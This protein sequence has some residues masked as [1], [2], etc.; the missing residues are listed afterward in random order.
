MHNSSATQVSASTVDTTTTGL[1][2]GVEGAPLDDD[3]SS[4]YLHKYIIYGSLGALLG[5]F[6]VVFTIGL[7]VR[8]VKKKREASRK[9]SETRD[10][11]PANSWVLMCHKDTTPERHASWDYTNHYQPAIETQPCSE[12]SI[13]NPPSR[14]LG[15]T[16]PSLSTF[17]STATATVQRTTGKHIV[18][19]EVGQPAETPVDLSTGLEHFEEYPP[20]PTAFS[21]AETER[22]AGENVGLS[23]RAEQDL[24]DD[25]PPPPPEAFS[26]YETVPCVGEE[27][28][29]PASC[30][31]AE[32]QEYVHEQSS[33]WI[34]I[35]EAYTYVCLRGDTLLHPP[36]A[37]QYFE[38]DQLPPS[39]PSVEDTPF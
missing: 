35:G 6:V 32:T 31:V 21:D 11:A 22:P 34:P 28:L 26:E 37:E 15:H 30:D 8:T 19:R 33:S 13:P 4:L 18:K 9:R 5:A 39:S 36:V 14:R 10:T 25:L 24:Q 29:P 17:L 38:D 23:E 27:P 20:P 3:L 2:A 7:V 16:R 1:A 12:I